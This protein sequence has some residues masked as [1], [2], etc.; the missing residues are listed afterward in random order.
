MRTASRGVRTRLQ[1]RTAGLASPLSAPKMC[2][3]EKRC[4]LQPFRSRSG[5]NQVGNEPLTGWVS[6]DVM[7][8]SKTAA[9]GLVRVAGSPEFMESPSAQPSHRTLVFTLRSCT[10]RLGLNLQRGCLLAVSEGA[11]SEQDGRVSSRRDKATAFSGG[12]AHKS[13][14]WI[15]V[16][17]Q[18]SLRRRGLSG[19]CGRVPL[20]L[21]TQR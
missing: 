21:R 12:T 4:L 16:L 1:K 17:I 10:R 19:W 5:E 11:S 14:A 7:T 13:N 20:L 6:R 18:Q 9:S 3:S 2:D 15:P 8:T